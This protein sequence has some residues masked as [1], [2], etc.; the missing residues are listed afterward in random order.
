MN[1]GYA[2]LL[3]QRVRTELEKSVKSGLP[4]GAA[5]AML[6]FT[7]RTVQSWMSVGFRAMDQRPKKPPKGSMKIELP[8]DRECTALEWYN[9]ELNCLSLAVA[10]LKTEGALV[11]KM[12]QKM[13]KG[14]LGNVPDGQMQRFLFG[15]YTHVH[16]LADKPVSTVHVTSESSPDAEKPPLQIYLPHNGR[17]EPA[18]PLSKADK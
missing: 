11:G 16:G 9:H 18:V 17:E 2:P 1:T 5:A 3:Q 6:G 14:A 13:W 8:G 4:I 7:A 15:K 10:V 12:V